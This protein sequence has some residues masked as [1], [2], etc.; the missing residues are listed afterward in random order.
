MNLLKVKLNKHEISAATENGDLFPLKTNLWHNKE[1]GH[2]EHNVGM[3]TQR[4]L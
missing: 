1:I 2:S 4:A 3:K